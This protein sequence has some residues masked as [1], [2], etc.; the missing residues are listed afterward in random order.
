[1]EGGVPFPCMIDR[2]GVTLMD[3]VAIVAVRLIARGVSPQIVNVSKSKF[4]WEI[5]CWHC[6][7]FYCSAKTQIYFDSQRLVLLPNQNILMLAEQFEV[8]LQEILIGV[9]DRASELDDSEAFFP[10]IVQPLSF[11]KP[12]F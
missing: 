12:R 6:K 2:D 4:L 9:S 8:P 10:F 1:M 11:S 7:P 3:E 5:C